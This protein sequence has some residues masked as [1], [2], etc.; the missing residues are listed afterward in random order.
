MDIGGEAAVSY[1]NNQRRMRQLKAETTIEFGIRA[2][3]YLQTTV[4]VKM[5][6][7]S[8]KLDAIGCDWKG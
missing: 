7:G 8:R 1:H 4:D 3:L 5:A 2:G 6:C